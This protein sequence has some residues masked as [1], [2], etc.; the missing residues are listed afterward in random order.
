MDIFFSDPDKVP[1][2]PEEVRILKLEASPWPDGQRVAVRI[3]VTPFQKR[4]N[5]EIAIF[6]HEGAR[7]ANLSVVEAMEAVFEFTMHLRE[8]EPGGEYQV[9]ARLFYSAIDDYEGQGEA[10][11]EQILDKVGETVDEA[12]A[13]FEIAAGKA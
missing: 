5:M 6:N 4:P 8:A 13:S 7:V 2:P 9:K 12:E 11:A 10:S 1:L 3:E